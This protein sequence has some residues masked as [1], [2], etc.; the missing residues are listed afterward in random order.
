MHVTQFQWLGLESF[1]HPL[2]LNRLWGAF[3]NVP[4]TGRNWGPSDTPGILASTT[5][6]CQYKGGQQPPFRNATHRTP[7]KTELSKVIS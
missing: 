1:I 3:A 5:E 6:Q 7:N 2:T 4:N